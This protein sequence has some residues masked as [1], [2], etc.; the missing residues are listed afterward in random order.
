MRFCMDGREGAAYDARPMRIL[1]VN[2]L[3]RYL[4][5]TLQ[6]GHVRI[7]VLK[8]RILA[9]VPD[10]YFVRERDPRMVLDYLREVGL[11]TTIR[12]V[13]SRSRENLRNEKFVSC[14]LGVVTES[15]E[16]ATRSSGEPV[17]FIA[18]AHPRCM[19]RVVLPEGLTRS[20][21]AAGVT[22]SSSGLAHIDL[23]GSFRAPW[24]EALAG[25]SVYSGLPLPDD[26]VRLAQDAIPGLLANRAQ[27]RTLSMGNGVVI[28]RTRYKAKGGDSR[29]SAALFGLGNYAKTVVLPSVNSALRIECIHEIDPTQIGPRTG[30]GGIA[31]DS[32]PFPRDDERYNAVFVAGFHHTHADIAIEA[33][34]LG[35]A[36]VVEKPVVTTESQLDRLLEAL[37]AHH[38]RL[39]ACFQRRYLA[40]NTMARRDLGAAPEGPISYH[41]TVFEVPLPAAHWYRWPKSR[42]RLVSNGCHWIDHFL[43][44]NGFVAVD[45]QHIY[46]ARDGTLNVSLELAN[47]AVFTMVLTDRG[48]NRIGV[49]DYVELR[50]AQGTAS[51]TNTSSY[52]AERG[53]RLVRTSSGNRMDAY[54]KMYGTI[55]RAVADG[56]PGNSL[57][58]IESSCRVVLRLERE[59][60][61]QFPVDGRQGR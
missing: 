45:R 44:L 51:I 35:A 23:V 40:F 32:S 15:G 43:F 49:Q 61:E 29:P 42:S 50:T 37:R 30:M 36:A 18:P 41:A 59:L 52:R 34:R 16:G 26:A 46:R 31:Y 28:E 19:E 1:G 12:K 6:P 54:R 9:P 27:D 57:A 14:G 33:L 8:W 4:D 2:W 5:E 13:L 3:D 20:A 21:S 60:A 56:S 39:F 24:L 55:A 47:G 25:W 17:Y 38:G 7:Q 11:L 53:K 48:A 58:S 22:E 10:L